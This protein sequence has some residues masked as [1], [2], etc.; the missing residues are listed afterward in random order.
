[1]KLASIHNHR[2]GGRGVP[3]PLRGKNRNYPPPGEK[4]EGGYDPPLWAKPRRGVPPPYE[5]KISRATRAKFFFAP[6]FR[7][8][9]FLPLKNTEF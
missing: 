7:K 4:P 2:G 3:P 1:M 9:F 8:K 6:F 5:K